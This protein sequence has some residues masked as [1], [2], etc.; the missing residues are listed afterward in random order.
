MRSRSFQAFGVST[1][2]RAS[3]GLVSP[4][5]GYSLQ[6]STQPI[7]GRDI[8]PTGTNGA[9]S[10][11]AFAAGTVSVTATTAAAT[12]PAPNIS[13]GLH[14]ILWPLPDPWDHISHKAFAPPLIQRSRFE[15]NASK[16]SR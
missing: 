10:L 2:S 1:T 3:I 7:G 16:E 8:A 14:C 15:E 11:A 5:L 12:T 9:R 13:L 6:N 4:S